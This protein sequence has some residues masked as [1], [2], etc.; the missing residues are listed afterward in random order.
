MLCLDSLCTMRCCILLRADSGCRTVS[1]C[2][3]RQVKM[4]Q[5]QH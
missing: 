3:L 2:V 1:M 5:G 4:G